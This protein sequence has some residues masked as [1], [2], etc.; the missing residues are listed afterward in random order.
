MPD[1]E[2]M[3]EAAKILMVVTVTLL[4]VAALIQI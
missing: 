2:S 1:S 4:V 3:M